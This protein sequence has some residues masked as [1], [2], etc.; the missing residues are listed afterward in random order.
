MKNDFWVQQE[1]RQ[2][3]YRASMVVEASLILPL[4]LLFS[5]VLIFWIRGLTQ[6]QQEQLALSQTVAKASIRANISENFA[7][8]GIYADYAMGKSTSGVLLPDVF[9][10]TTIDVRYQTIVPTFPSVVFSSEMPL[11]HR[12]RAKRWDGDIDEG[13]GEDYVY[14]TKYGTVYHENLNC[15]YLKPSTR[16]VE[17]EELLHLRNEGGATYQRCPLCVGKEKKAG[18]YYV[19]RYGTAYHSM[20]NCRAL[21]REIRRI[22]RSEVGNRKGCSKCTQSK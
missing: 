6:H 1:R 7:L 22:P 8:G 5:L 16:A 19:T 20:A 15:P 9:N 3:R 10:A 18:T 11:G 14:V 12:V 21:R 2:E 17:P 13:D 4:L